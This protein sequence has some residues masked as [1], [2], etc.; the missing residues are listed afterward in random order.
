MQTSNVLRISTWNVNG[1]RASVRGG[2]E[3]WLARSKNSIVC[4]QEVK[5][6][7]DLLTR[8]WFHPYEAYWNGGIRRGYSGVATLI[9]LPLKPLDVSLGIGDDIL[10]REGRVLTTEFESFV[11]INAYAPH[12]HRKL[13]RLETKIRFCERF[14]VYVRDRLGR[15]KPVVV[16]GDLNVAHTTEDL[17]NPAG[18]KNN[19]GFLQVERDWMTALLGEGFVDTF[20]MFHS[21]PGYY[22]WWSS[23]KGVRERNVGWRLDYILADRLLADRIVSCFHSPEQ[24]GSDHCPVTVN[25]RV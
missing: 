22:T 5:M 18:N 25:I 7:E 20:R 9:K 2:F 6:Q 19:A 24:L 17:S 1:L 13:V 16:A 14:L 11:L 12:S 23:R 4:L 8:S 10:D 15:G 3:D 21:G